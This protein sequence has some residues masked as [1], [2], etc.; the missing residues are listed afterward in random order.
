[1]A[2]TFQMK[3]KSET[4][5]LL[6]AGM[7]AFENEQIMINHGEMKQQQDRRVQQ[8]EE[9]TTFWK[10]QVAAKNELTVKER[11]AAAAYKKLPADI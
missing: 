4:Q 9:V 2:L 10:E 8:K 6:K 3:D 1:M 7:H 5:S 11:E